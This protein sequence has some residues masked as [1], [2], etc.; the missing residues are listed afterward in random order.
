MKSKSDSSKDR[1]QKPCN[2]K[3]GK[4]MLHELP[5]ALILFNSFNIYTS[6]VVNF[7]AFGTSNL[8]VL[9]ISIVCILIPPISGI[10]FYRFRK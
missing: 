9:L 4:A 2:L 1:H 3:Y 10:L 7:Q 6:A 8:S 5:F